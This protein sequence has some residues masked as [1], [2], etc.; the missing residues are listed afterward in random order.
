MSDFIPLW[1]S[2]LRHT[3][4]VVVGA[5]DAGDVA[6]GLGR[7]V[8]LH[9]AADANPSV[10][11][12]QRVVA[13]RAHARPVPGEDGRSGAVCGDGGGAGRLGPS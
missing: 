6:V 3:A 9:A 12:D 5:R 2:A 11:L 4:A 7:A 8:R 10:L 1:R 13:R